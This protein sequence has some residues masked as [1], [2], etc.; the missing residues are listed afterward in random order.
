MGWNQFIPKDWHK[1]L[2]NSDSYM[3]WA[4][5][6]SKNIKLVEAI[7]FA[8]PVFQAWNQR[9]ANAQYMN[10]YKRNTGMSYK[11]TYKALEGQGYQGVTH[12]TSDLMNATFKFLR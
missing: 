1:G 10:D 3:D 6:N 9:E 5:R 4:N 11:Y 7:P 8:G 12:A 2:Y